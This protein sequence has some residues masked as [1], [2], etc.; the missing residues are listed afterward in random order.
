MESI[1]PWSRHPLAH[2][3]RISDQWFAALIVA[4]QGLLEAV[5]IQGGM[6]LEHPLNGEPY[7]LD[8]ARDAPRFED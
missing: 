8:E 3:V 2:L 1:E 5:G 6:R 7:Q 4:L